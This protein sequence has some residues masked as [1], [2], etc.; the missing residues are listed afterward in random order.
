M[1][2]E[3][4]VFLLGSSGFQFKCKVAAVLFSYLLWK[5]LWKVPSPE[6]WLEELVTVSIVDEVFGGECITCARV[7]DGASLRFALYEWKQYSKLMR[8]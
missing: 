2:V 5:V 4:A 1:L 6:G 7:G 3:L 8:T